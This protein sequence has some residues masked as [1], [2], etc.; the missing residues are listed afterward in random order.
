M[1]EERFVGLDLARRLAEAR[2]TIAAR[3]FGRR[4]FHALALDEHDEAA[5]L[6]TSE[7]LRTLLAEVA[8]RE[9]T[10]ATVVDALADGV[11]RMRAELVAR[12]D[13]LGGDVSART[14]GHAAANN[15]TVASSRLS[16]LEREVAVLTARVKLL[17]ALT[18]EGPS[19][20]DRR[21]R[22]AGR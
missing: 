22:S 13:A 21:L 12:I 9:R 19:E 11:D 2:R 5:E 18:A 4:L 16:S 10:L 7:L 20:L 1:Q 14:G 8:E 17:E 6:P 15:G 3:G